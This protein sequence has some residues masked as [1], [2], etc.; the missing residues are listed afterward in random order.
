MRHFGVTVQDNPYS[1]SP[2]YIES[3]DRDFVLLLILEGT[4]I[5]AH[6]R[7]PTGKELATCRHI[8]LYSH[9]EWNPHIVKFPKDLRSVEEEIEYRKPIASIRSPVATILYDDNDKDDDIQGYQR[10]L[11]GSVKV[12]S[13]VKLNIS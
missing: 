4:K 6:T 2:L 5:L 10:R 12:T 1:N 7:N 11:I 9:H 8:L 13:A 3:T